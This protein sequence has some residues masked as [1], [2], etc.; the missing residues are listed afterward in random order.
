MI[1]DKRRLQQ[2][3]ILCAC[4]VDFVSD[5]PRTTPTKVVECRALKDL[6]KL[7]DRFFAFA[8]ASADS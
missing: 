4:C 2:T 1:H 5:E 6:Y 7:Q 8:K 3:I